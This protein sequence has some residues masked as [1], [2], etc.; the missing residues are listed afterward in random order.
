G[1]PNLNQNGTPAPGFAY[2]EEDIKGLSRAL[3]GW[4]YGDGDL[5]TVPTG[6]A[7]ED[8]TVP[9]EPV[10]RFHDTGEKVFLGGTIPPGQTARK[11]LDDALDIVFRHPNLGPFVARHF[12]QTMVT[13]NPS[14]Q[15]I[16]DIAA[17][18]N[19]NGSGVRGDLQAIVRAMLLHPEANLGPNPQG[20]L[21]EPALFISSMFRTLNAQVADHPVLTDYSEE[22]GQKVLYP[23]SVFSYFSPGFRIRG[24]GGLMGPEY[25]ILTSVTSLSRTNFAGRV[26]SGAFGGDVTID[27]TEF[28]N[29]ANDAAAL[30][31][32]CN[33]LFLGGQMSLQLRTEIINAVQVTP[34]TN[35]TERV[36][37]ALYLILA[38]AQYQ[39][40]R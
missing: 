13:S 20:K 16:S 11:D 12:I 36:R 9:M 19:N 40:D 7:R 18:F 25:Q 29:R 35:P 4:T 21:M 30:V 24:L 28:R 26:I 1:I 17:V 6:D 38:S 22:M 33:T 10:Q 3:T 31:D 15:F 34:A 23:P 5:N 39:V 8:Y 32:Y 14:P 37:T 27:Y 2:T